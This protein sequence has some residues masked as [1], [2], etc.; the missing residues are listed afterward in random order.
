VSPM[1]I[2]P[3]ATRITEPRSPDSCMLRA[4]CRRVA[5]TPF[6]NALACSRQRCPFS[7][8]GQACGIAGSALGMTARRR[9]GLAPLRAPGAG[10][11]SDP[12]TSVA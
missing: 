12:P 4:A 9:G 11:A 10:V 6:L 5:A 7:A 3:A 8:L 1:G 2:R